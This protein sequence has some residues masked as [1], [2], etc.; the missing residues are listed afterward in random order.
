MVL[1]S[2][3]KFNFLLLLPSSYL[4]SLSSIDIYLNNR[5]CMASQEISKKHWGRPFGF[6]ISYCLDNIRT[7]AFYWFYNEHWK[8]AVQYVVGKWRYNMSQIRISRPS[9]PLPL[10]ISSQEF[11]NSCF[12]VVLLFWGWDE[13]W[14]RWRWSSKAEVCTEYGTPGP[15][16][17]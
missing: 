10:S 12:V 4:T 15:F 3:C 7:F 1:L 6:L 11:S 9:R 14:G 5:E 2:L 16:S 13:V 8:E 17:P